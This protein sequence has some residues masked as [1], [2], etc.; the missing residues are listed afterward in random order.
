[1]E[2]CC[3]HV[4]VVLTTTICQD[5]L[6]KNLACSRLSGVLMPARLVPRESPGGPRCGSRPRDRSCRPEP[7]LDVGREAVRPRAMA[8]WQPR[9]R[10]R[11]SFAD[12]RPTIADHQWSAAPGVG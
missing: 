2:K 8:R 4:N 1:M 9:R 11:W 3:P 6:D 5:H 7:A 10:C 12:P